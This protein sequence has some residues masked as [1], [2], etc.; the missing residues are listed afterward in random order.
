M[1]PLKLS[2]VPLLFLPL[3]AGWADTPE[4]KVVEQPPVKP[5][6]P[7][8]I[9]VG[10]PAWISAVSGTTGFRGVTTYV[11]VDAGQIGR[12]LNVALSFGGEVR[13][14][15]FGAFGDLLYLNAQAGAGGTGLVSNVALGLQ[16]FLGEFNLS[17]RLLEGPH[18]WL[19]LF[20]GFRYAYLGEQLGLQPNVPVIQATSAELVNA[21]AQQLSTPN[22]DVR[23]LVQQSIVTRL[24]SLQGRKPPL[25]VAP[26]FGHQTGTIRDSVQQA[27]EGRRA[28]LAA[29]VRAGVQARVSQ[30]KAQLAT[31]IANRLTNQLNRSASF[32]DDW[33]D[34]VIGLRGRLNLGKAFYLTAQSDVGGFGI[35]SDVAVQEYA[36]LGCQIT[37]HLYSEVGY[38]FLYDDFRDA[39]FLYELAT[40]GAQITF[41]LRF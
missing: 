18:G 22:S 27:F 15:R 23:T 2:I 30:L 31:E 33:V 35:G 41:G 13:K 29:A 11:D 6:E 12:H 10:A 8:Q 17:W 32:Y 9:T 37:R 38:R 20:A 28:E 16:E 1:N 39:N 34:P 4:A 21:F 19:D 5:T 7:W 3:L 25:P 36:A 26:L 24:T 14:G 40:H